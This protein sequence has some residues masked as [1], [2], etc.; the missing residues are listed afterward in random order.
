VKLL[1]LIADER[2]NVVSVEHHREGMVISIGETEVEL[3]LSARDEEHC[4]SLLAAMERW[5]YPV[6]RLR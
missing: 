4:A 5:G 3:T 1:T 6:E 2:I